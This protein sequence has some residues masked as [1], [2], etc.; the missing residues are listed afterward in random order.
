MPTTN[1]GKRPRYTFII[2][3]MAVY[4]NRTCKT[5]GKHCKSKQT[6]SFRILTVSWKCHN[7]T[8]LQRIGCITSG[9]I[10]RI[11]SKKGHTFYYTND[12]VLASR[13]V[14]KKLN[15]IYKDTSQL[16]HYMARPR[17]QRQQYA[18][19]ASN[20]F[21]LL[22][23]IFIIIFIFIFISLLY[24]YVQADARGSVCVN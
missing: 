14:A 23:T 5:V 15:T 10:W 9:I 12:A 19:R 24:G 20:I 4:L 8:L 11:T 3:I 7:I 2:F 1:L 21:L 6:R 18:S 13:A 22:D 16:I 17:L